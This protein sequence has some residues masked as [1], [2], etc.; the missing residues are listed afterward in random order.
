VSAWFLSYGLAEVHPDLLIGALPLDASDVHA[1]R[2]L[3][4]RRVLNLVEDREYPQGAR[5]EVQ[6]ALAEAQIEE[7]RLAFEDFGGLTAE[8][9]EQGVT[10]VLHWLAEGERTYVHCRAGWQRSAAIAAGVVAVRERLEI[11]EALELVTARK[12]SAN[13]LP[14]QREDLQRWWEGH[15]PSELLIPAE[16]DAD[17]EQAELPPSGKWVP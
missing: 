7:Q 16:P 2:R 8:A 1:L 14:H 4:V 10:I 17:S 11:D 3:G 6:A 15:E 5:D 12:P 9:L 13:P